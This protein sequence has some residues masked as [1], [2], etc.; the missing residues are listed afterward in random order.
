[1]TLNDIENAV[2]GLS[3]EELQ[4]FRAW[5]TQFDT[6]VWDRQIES[7]L[8]TGKLDAL[9]DAALKSHQEGKTQEL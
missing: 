1:M 9:A 5:F 2:V 7:D 6:T 4:R 8:Q 3:P